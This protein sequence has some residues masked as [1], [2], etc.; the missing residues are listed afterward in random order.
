MQSSSITSSPGSSAKQRP[1][2]SYFP[3]TA[4]PHRG[5]LVSGSGPATTCAAPDVIADVS[6]HTPRSQPALTP[7]TPDAHTPPGRGG[8]GRSD[9]E[10]T[11]MRTKQAKRRGNRCGETRQNRNRYRMLTPLTRE[12]GGSRAPSTPSR[13]LLTP[14]PD[15]EPC[16]AFRRN[17][18]ERE[19]IC[20]AVTPLTPLMPRRQ[21][22]AACRV[23][24]GTSI[25]WRCVQ[26]SGRVSAGLQRSGSGGAP[27]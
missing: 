8:R 10:R 7:H 22:E 9:R 5:R 17:R 24:P 1:D 2:A 6:A 26:P 19:H 14:V 23:T 12:R 27:A 16:T 11:T 25:G 3:Q 15:A 13:V 20:D 21:T 18:A 4:T